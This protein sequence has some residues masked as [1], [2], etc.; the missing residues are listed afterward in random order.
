MNLRPIKLLA[1][2]PTPLANKGPAEIDFVVVRENTEDFYVGI[3]G[4]RA[5]GEAGPSSRSSARSTP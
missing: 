4:G 3:G 1:G 2:V 5:Q